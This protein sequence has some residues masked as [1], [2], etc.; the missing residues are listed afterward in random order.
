MGNDQSQERNHTVRVKVV[1]VNKDNSYAGEMECKREMS[2]SGVDSYTANQ[3]VEKERDLMRQQ[4]EISMSNM[5][6]AAA[7]PD[8]ERRYVTYY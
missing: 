2:F 5:N 8:N 1:A 6:R 4:M 7:L 3:L